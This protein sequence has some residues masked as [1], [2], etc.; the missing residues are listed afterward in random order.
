MTTPAKRRIVTD[1]RKMLSD[2]REGIHAFP[3][4]N[5][6]LKWKATI[7]GPEET[8]WEGGT[9]WF[10]LTFTENY[11]NEPPII[12]FITPIFHPNIYE[13]GN[14]CLDILEKK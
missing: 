10:S 3:D 7:I 5:N 8:L 9:F 14:I 2:P 12:K 1:L 13:N 11:P 6:I 4:K